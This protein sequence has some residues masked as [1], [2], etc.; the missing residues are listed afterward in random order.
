MA[1]FARLAQLATVGQP[2][3]LGQQVGRGGR[4]RGGTELSGFA[5]R[6]TE[7]TALNTE[8]LGLTGAIAVSVLTHL[9]PP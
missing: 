9:S 1:F 7:F 8:L 3:R 4:R 5:K 2:A 6:Q